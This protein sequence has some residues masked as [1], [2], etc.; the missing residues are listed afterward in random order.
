MRSEQEYVAL[1]LAGV[2]P[3]D[4]VAR[5]IAKNNAA[6]G[7]GFRPGFSEFLLEIAGKLEL[8]YQD[9]LMQPF[10]VIGRECE[11]RL[12]AFPGP[13]IV[14]S[15]RRRSPHGGR[16]ARDGAIHGGEQM[17]C[18]DGTFVFIEDAGDGGHLSMRPQ[19]GSLIQVRPEINRPIVAWQIHPSRAG[20]VVYRDNVPGV[21]DAVYELRSRYGEPPVY[22]PRGAVAEWRVD[23]RDFTVK[24]SAIPIPDVIQTMQPRPLRPVPMW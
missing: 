20:E 11:R 2:S 6:T 19:R 5:L 9:R 1:R 3:A 13:R 24:P 15:H 12:W 17:R 8:H 22:W 16:Y 14:V 23:E 4:A 18:A 7:L 21:L 10:R